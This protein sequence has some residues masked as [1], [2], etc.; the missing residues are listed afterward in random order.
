[1]WRCREQIRNFKSS[2]KP[3]CSIAEG[4]AEW[5]NGGV[6]VAEAVGN[7]PDNWRNEVLKINF[8][9]LISFSFKLLFKFFSSSDVT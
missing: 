3:E 6:D 9:S 2:L 7:V 1:M 8:V 4:V 5:V